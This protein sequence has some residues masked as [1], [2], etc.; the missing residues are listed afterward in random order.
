MPE[1][2]HKK[3]DHLGVRVDRRT[4]AAKVTRGVIGRVVNVGA[5]LGSTPM[6]AAKKNPRAR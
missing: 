5:G 4:K 2:I 6:Y 1:G 3:D